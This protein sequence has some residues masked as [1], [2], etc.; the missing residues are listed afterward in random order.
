[1][2]FFFHG[3]PALKRLDLA[4]ACLFA[5][6]SELELRGSPAGDVEETRA[7]AAS[8]YARRCPRPGQL[9]QTALVLAAASA[10]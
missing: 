3:P 6:D 9:K 1:M 5:C 2:E 4:W 7:A 8:Q 10:G